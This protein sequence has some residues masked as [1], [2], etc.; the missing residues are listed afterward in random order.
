[1]KT[2]GLSINLATVRKQYKLK[3][4]VEA[5][6]KHGV[7][8]ISPWREHVQEVGMAEAGRII[9]GN[10]MKVTGYCRGGLFGSADA[11]GQQALIDDNK[12]MIDEGAAIGADCLVM[13]GGGLAPGSRDIKAARGRYLDGMA[14]ILPHARACGVALAVEP[15]HPAYA[16]DR[17]CVSLLS[18]ALDIV[19]QL[20]EGS[21]V[22][23]DAYHL[24]W[25]PNLETQ[26]KRAK[27]KI[28]AHHICDWLVPTK[29]ILL[30]RGMMGD[31]VIDLPGLRRM[32]EAAGFTG[33]QEV[34]IFS[35]KDWWTRPGDEVIRT[36][37]E[38]YNTV[39]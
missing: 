20:G 21:G 24:W 32:V 11:N 12:R 16:A 1:M 7:R 6:V 35:E 18:E 38:R 14:A 26:M 8:G 3:D 27:G 29:D 2:E 5:F 17:G 15:L 13:I 10:G 23:I 4:G 33:Y 9:R 34:E 39:C 28:L 31:G 36:C 19:D 25:D 37:I 22:V 30:D